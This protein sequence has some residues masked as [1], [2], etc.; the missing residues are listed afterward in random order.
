MNNFAKEIIDTAETIEELSVK[1]KY[2]ISFYS[3]TER[4]IG[5]NIPY[6]TC[7]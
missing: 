7:C 3:S 4:K 6:Y 2:W 5:Y 1:E